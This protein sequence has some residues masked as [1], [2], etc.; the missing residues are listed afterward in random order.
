MTEVEWLG[1]RDPDTLLTMLPPPVSDRKLRLFVAAAHR[2]LWHL[3]TD[4]ERRVPTAAE[5]FLEGKI[6][7]DQFD[8]A[9]R[10]NGL[11]P[12][13]DRAPLPAEYPV[14]RALGEVEYI[15]EDAGGADLDSVVAAQAQLVRDILGNPPRPVGC[16]PAWRTG[17]GGEVMR[18]AE[19]IYEGRR[20]PD[21]TLEPGRL[22]ALADAL[23]RAGCTNEDLLSHLRT[24][25][26]HVLGCWAID[27]V[28]GRE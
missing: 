12:G 6:T 16:A 10:G 28:L 17:E 19:A 20:L 8:A 23:E 21:G 22:A 25:G 18:L 3:L 2:H 27:L 13:E 1:A 4:L 9:Y 5:Q 7:R 14:E 24:P 11:F 26:P 15:T